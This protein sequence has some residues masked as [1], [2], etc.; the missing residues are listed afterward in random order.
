[1]LAWC[2]VDPSE[3]E[4]RERFARIGIEAGRAFDPDD[5]SPE[6][7][8]AIEAGMA[9]AWAVFD[10]LRAGPIARGEL[11]SGDMFGT[12]EFLGNNYLYRLAAAVTG[13]WGNSREEAMYPIYSVDANGDPLD[14][15]KHAYR[16]HAEPGVTIPADAFWS[17]TMY[18]M[19]ASL[20]YANEIDRYLINSPMV[21][22]LVRD[23]DGGVTIYLQHESPGADKE[24]N[25]LP[26]PQGAFNLVLRMCGPR[27]SPPTILD[28]SW[29]PPPVERV[30]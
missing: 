25:W 30:P 18:E 3:T 26:A 24:A 11:T 12:R 6:M 27:T 7:R 23:P 5:L 9:D 4:L 21:S 8:A 22:D 14:G 16:L 28:G 10:S 29:A 15:S 1:V 13:I 20:L 17:L 19:P 2:P